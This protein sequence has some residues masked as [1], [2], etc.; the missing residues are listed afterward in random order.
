MSEMLFGEIEQ[1]LKK[2]TERDMLDLIHRR[3]ARDM[4]NGPRY[5]VAEHVRN[6]GGFG[7]AYGTHGALRIAD[8]IAIDVWPSAGHFIEGFEVK[9]SR[10]DWLT[11]LKDPTKAEAFKPYCHRWWLVAPFEDI[12]RDDLPSGWGL[13]VPD[14]L[15]SL[16]IR[17]RAAQREPEQM[18]LTL[19]AAWAR[20]IAKTTERRIHAT[21][22]EGTPA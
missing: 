4:G 16:R 2:W 20:A 18:P 10:S 12:V 19:M 7:G 1:P 3:Y 11:E 21:R 5:V 13:M 9:V 8:A 6:Q 15:G 22:N 14:K 17:R